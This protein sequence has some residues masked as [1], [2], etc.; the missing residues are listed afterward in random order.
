MISLH[1]ITAQ[2]W[3]ANRAQVLVA[4]SVLLC[5][6]CMPS[7]LRGQWPASGGSPGWTGGNVGIGTA[8][9]GAKLEVNGGGANG[10]MLL[11]SGGTSNYTFL[12]LGRTTYEA[13]IAMSPG[14]GNFSPAAQAG[15]LVIRSE[16]KNILFTTDSGSTNQ[17][18]LK[19]GGWVG[20]GTVTP[21]Q[22]GGS[23]FTCLLTVNG[24]MA[25]KEII[26]TTGITADYVFKPDYHLKPLTEVA[27]FIQE[28]HHLPEIPSEA[29]VKVNGISV[30]DMQVKLLA[31][32][33]EL[34]LHMI[35]AEERN[36]RLDQQNRELRER[37]A[38]L[39]ARNGKNDA[40]PSDSGEKR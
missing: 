4:I 14:P 35:Q 2:F 29:E 38:R 31:K 22:C 7:Q 16:G 18:Y 28:H 39:E 15:D 37:L 24:A 5:I 9:P 8:N 36:N 30:G 20:I 19:N 32:V 1:R 12:A 21:G 23:T 26:V 34:T 33:E 40:E 13:M 25:A 3:F 17:M 10:G 11:Y 27:S 6:I